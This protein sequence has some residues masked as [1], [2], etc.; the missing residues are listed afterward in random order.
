[1]ENHELSRAELL[2]HASST[3][4][5]VPTQKKLAFPDAMSNR[6][7]LYPI[8]KWSQIKYK[9]IR[10]PFYVWCSFLPV[11]SSDQWPVSPAF[12]LYP[13]V[14][15]H[16]RNA[17]VECGWMMETTLKLSGLPSKHAYIYGEWILGNEHFFLALFMFI[18]FDGV[19][20]RKKKNIN[21]KSV[22]V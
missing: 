5:E 20:K 2:L 12:Y 21:G 15:G 4:G 22:Q 13:P 7:F 17:R 16:S 3:N 11:Y 18:P 1:M 19:A 10:M 8:D 9:I 6:L 14:V